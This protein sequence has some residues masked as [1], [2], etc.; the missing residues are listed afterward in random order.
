MDNQIKK[1]FL[2]SFLALTT[3]IAAYF[4]WESPV[5]LVIIL[6][7]ISLLMLWLEGEKNAFLVFII[8]FV[9]GPLFEGFMIHSGAWEYAVSHILGFPIWLPFVWGNAALFIKR[10]YFSINYLSEKSQN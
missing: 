7:T 8:V 2:N 6:G 5:L 10:L 1:S 4:L 9:L 3:F